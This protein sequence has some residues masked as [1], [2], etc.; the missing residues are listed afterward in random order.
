VPTTPGPPPVSWMH[1]LNPHDAAGRTIFVGV[2]DACFVDEPDAG[3]T[4][5]TPVDCP[6]EFDDPSWSYCVEGI[7]YRFAPR[8]E[9]WCRP[10]VPFPYGDQ[11]SIDIK[12]CPSRRWAK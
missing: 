10:K 5:R 7:L 4:G 11:P 1:R 12:P 9:C 8:G 6:L 3:P 2:D